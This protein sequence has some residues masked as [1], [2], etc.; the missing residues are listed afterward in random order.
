LAAIVHQFYHPGWVLLAGGALAA[1]AFHRIRA[2][3]E[4]LFWSCTLLV[5]MF[6][7]VFGGGALMHRYLYLVSIPTVF[8]YTLLLREA[9]QR[10]PGWTVTAVVL[11]ILV[12]NLAQ[13]IYIEFY[14]L[15]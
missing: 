14:L 8:L 13:L 1:I 10:I 5:S 11:F 15:Y 9:S 6:P 7:T 3:K 12:A 4:L 2:R